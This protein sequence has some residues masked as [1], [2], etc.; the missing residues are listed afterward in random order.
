[1]SVL[2]QSL[3][4]TLFGMGLVFAALALL[5]GLMS[6]LTN[7]LRDKSPAPASIEAAPASDAEE[8]TRAA[9]AAVSVALAQQSQTSARPLTPSPTMLIGAWQLGMRTRQMT[10]KG[11]MGRR[12]KD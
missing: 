6:L 12:N 3:W 10:Q 5:A 7:L 11:E 2:S 4:I 9:A 1:M 8:V